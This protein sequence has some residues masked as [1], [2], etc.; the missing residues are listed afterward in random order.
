MNASDEHW[1]RHALDQ[2]HEA[3][4]SGEVPVGAVLVKDG[5]VI[6]TG[7]NTSVASHDPSGHAEINA[8][9]AGARALGN[10]RLDGCELFVTLEPCAMCAGAMLHARLARVVYGARDP[11]TGAAGSVVDLFGLHQLNHRTRV[12]SDV[13]SDICG[14]VLQDFFKRRRLQARQ[15]SQPLR[16]DAL[17][18]PEVRFNGFIDRSTRSCWSAGGVVQRGWRMHWLDSSANAQGVPVLCLH[19]PG[20]WGYYFRNLMSM[21]KI[22]CLVPDLIGFGRSDKPK[23]DAIHEWS[24]HRDVVLEWL[25]TLEVK[26]MFLACA[27][28][29][30]PLMELLV[31]KIPD[32][33]DRDAIVVVPDE[34]TGTAVNAWKAPFPDRGHE[35]ALRAL[36]PVD[37]TSSGPSPEQAREVASDIA[38]RAAGTMGYCRP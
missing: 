6:A 26:P 3:E 5:V 34:R 9:R 2:A 22:R 20:Q 18:T 36:G 17:R 16:D 24:W 19:G 28:S 1:M 8:L 31:A 21:E 25:N 38:S 37:E 30:E 12:E 4:A 11:K 13:L 29:A 35:A 10:H 14:G 7:R 27:R 15:T 23:R 33:V 32:L